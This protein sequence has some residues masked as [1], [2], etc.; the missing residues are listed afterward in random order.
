MSYGTE[1]VLVLAREKIFTPNSWRGVNSDREHIQKVILLTQSDA[2]FKERDSVEED[3]SMKQIIPYLVF[4]YKDRNFLMHRSGEGKERRL[5]NKFSLGIGGHIREE[6][7]GSENVFKW[8]ER[9]F[10]E[11]VSYPGKFTTEILGLLNDDE[12]DKVGNVHLG[13]LILVEGDSPEIKIRDEHKSGQLL[14]L[15]GI[16]EHREE[17]ESWSKFVYD[18]LVDQAMK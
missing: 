13:I 6:D 16:G 4:R 5:H 11:E 14:P 3:P 12:T 17:M 10:H 2:E 18:Y 9:E 1:R 7:V 8:A 15:N